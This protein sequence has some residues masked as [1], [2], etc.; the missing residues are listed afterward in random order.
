MSLPTQYT[1]VVEAEFEL[2]VGD[3]D[4]L[5][6]G[7]I[8]CGLVQLDTDA[9][10]LVGQL[11]ADAL[12][13]LGEADVLVVFAQLGLGRR[14]ENRLGQLGGLLPIPGGIGGID[15]GLIGTLIV[16]GAPAAAT[17]AAVLAYRLILFWLPLIIGGIAFAALRRDMPG[18][19]E[20]ASCAPAIAAQSA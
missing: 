11:G 7:I 15:G 2:G 5:G 10:N 8:G 13:H 17:A 14:R 19:Y 1:V 20:F 4:A 12:L 18:S 9:A 3:D 16:Y 6:R